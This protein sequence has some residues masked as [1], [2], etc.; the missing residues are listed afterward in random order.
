MELIIHDLTDNELEK[1][2]CEIEREEKIIDKIKESINQGKIIIDEDVSIICDNKKIKSC[3]GCFECWVKTPGKCKIR[4][5]YESL[6]KL[7]SEVEKIIIISQCFYGSYSP[8]VKNVLDRTIPYLLPFFKIKNREMHHITRNK[9]KFNLNVYFYGKN[10]TQNERAVAKEIV[11][12][13]SV[14]LDVKNFK[15]SFFEN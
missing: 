8:F 13:N 2:K 12:A 1:L 9:T 10:L 15:V 11:K 7:Y 14:N 4:D 5:G 3:M 6:G